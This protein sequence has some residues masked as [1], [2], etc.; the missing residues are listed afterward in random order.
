M[1]FLFIAD[2]YGPPSPC[3]QR[4]RFAVIPEEPS[5][6][7]SVNDNPNKGTRTPSPD[8]DFSIEVIVSYKNTQNQSLKKSMQKSLNWLLRVSR[9]CAQTRTTLTKWKQAEE[10]I[11][12]S[13][14]YRNKYVIVE[15]RLSRMCVHVSVCLWNFAKKEIAICTI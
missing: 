7:P 3:L 13:K 1:I 11:G 12:W 10:M 6:S 2:T 15:L 9:R 14:A 5:C 4:G 8:W